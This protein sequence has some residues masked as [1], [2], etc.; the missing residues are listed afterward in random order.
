MARGTIRVGL[1]VAVLAAGAWP[2][3]AQPICRE[4][5]LGQTVCPVTPPPPRD[6][7]RPTGS[8]AQGLPGAA[9]GTGGAVAPALIPSQRTTTLGQTFPLPGDLPGG[10][11]GTTCR[12][13]AL[14]HLR[15]R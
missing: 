10:A 8:G 3:A 14:G 9:E 5:E 7:R 2:G 6:P 15:C 1:L 13:D 4:N 11:A 12:R